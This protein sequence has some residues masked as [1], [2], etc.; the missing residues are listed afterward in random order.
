ML[1][2][3]RAVEQIGGRY[4]SGLQ[5]YLFNCSP[6]VCPTCGRSRFCPPLLPRGPSGGKMVITEGLNAIGFSS[7]CLTVSPLLLFGKKG[8]ITTITDTA[9]DRPE[10]V[11]ALALQPE[12]VCVCVCA[13]IITSSF[14]YLKAL[15][16]GK[17]H[18]NRFIAVMQPF[19]PFRSYSTRVTLVCAPL[20]PTEQ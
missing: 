15:P 13:H 10:L 19:S 1:R 14:F 6:R 17:V 18:G 16:L 11:R 3:L 20:T 4:L 9:D 5:P 12:A 2:S 7:T 8:I